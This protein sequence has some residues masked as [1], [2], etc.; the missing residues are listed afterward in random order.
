MGY[1]VTESYPGAAPHIPSE[2]DRVQS[3]TVINPGVK[4]VIPKPITDSHRPLFP[5]RICHHVVQLYQ[6]Q[7][8]SG[9]VHT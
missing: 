5:H 9:G 6:P 2:H 7:A 8:A 3:D 4:A 1:R